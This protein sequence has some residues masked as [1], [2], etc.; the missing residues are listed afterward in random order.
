MPKG[1]KGRDLGRGHL[2][3]VLG[4]GLRDVLI[5]EFDWN[6]LGFP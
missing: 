6:P 1:E 4:S 3:A 2:L 5:Q